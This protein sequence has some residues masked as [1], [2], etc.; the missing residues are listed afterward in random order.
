M[1]PNFINDGL[2]LTK[3]P[4]LLLQFVFYLKKIKF[5]PVSDPD[6][7][8][9]PKPDPKLTKGRIRIRY[10]IRNKSFGSATLHC[11]VLKL[12]FKGLQ[13]SMDAESFIT[14]R[15]S[16]IQEIFSNEGLSGSG[17]KGQ[18]GWRA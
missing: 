13:C 18:Q 15:S 2:I 4:Y 9:D 1:W 3:M 14:G 16:F 12:V 7:N 10:R 8:P 17:Q 6:S 5:W 11:T